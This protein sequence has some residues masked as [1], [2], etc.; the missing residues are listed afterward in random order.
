MFILSEQ[1][2]TDVSQVR[3]TKLWE[4]YQTFTEIKCG[5]NCHSFYSFSA[6][7]KLKL[8]KYEKKILKNTQNECQN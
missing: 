8:F 4:V 2:F 1:Y 3:E 7:L 5:R 6:N